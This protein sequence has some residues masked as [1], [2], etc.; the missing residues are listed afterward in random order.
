MTDIVVDA[1]LDVAWNYLNHGREFTRSAWD[2]RR[3]ETDPVLLA[4]Y[5][6]S[7]VGLPELLLGRVAVFGAAIFTSPAAHVMYPDERIFYKTPDE[8]YR[9]GKRQMD[10]YHQLADENEHIRLIQSK[11]DLDAVLATWAEGTQ[12]S[13][14]RVG[15]MLLLE[16]ADPILEPAQVEEWYAAGLRIIGPAWSQTRYSGGTLAVGPLTDLGRELLEVMMSFGM[17]LDLAHMAPEAAFEALDRYEGPLVASHAN[18]LRFRKDRPDRNLS[19]DL[20]R[21]IAER[22]GVIGIVPFNLFL[23]Q[24]WTRGDRR[25]VTSMETVIAA[26]DHV[27]QV[28]GSARHVGIGSDFDGGF[29]SESVPMGFETS[30]DL[31]Q[32]GRALAAKGYAPDDVSAILSGNFLRVLRAGL[33]DK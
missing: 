25:D 15:M 31:L 32:I 1:H 8:A 5:G 12:L 3:R 2:K 19:D 6:Y 10:Y 16:G 20:M 4:H 29:G 18:P 30:A 27:C 28:T 13:D 9:Q 24:G 17:I 26:I 14:H 11:A 7:M 22:D 33:P 23:V 21:G